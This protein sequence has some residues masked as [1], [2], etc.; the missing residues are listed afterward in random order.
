MAGEKHRK[1]LSPEGEGV[2]SVYRSGNIVLPNLDSQQVSDQLRPEDERLELVEIRTD[3]VQAAV[4]SMERLQAYTM[5]VKVETLWSDGSSETELTSYVRDRFTRVDVAQRDGSIRRTVT[6]GENTY[7]WY[8]DASYTVYASGS[9]S[10]DQELRVPTYEDLVEMPTESI[11]AATYQELKGLYCIYAEV[12]LGEGYL[13][14]Y[15]VDVETGLL[16]AAQRLHEGEPVYQMTV[17]SLDTATPD[18]QLF[19]LPDG[20]ELLPPDVAAASI[21]TGT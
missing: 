18:S 5:T 3:T 17:Q 6:D 13:G 16:I 14:R 2:R 4:D 11:V 10:A 8:D 21:E 19:R 7:I 20:T 1:I 15:W 9:I 12:N